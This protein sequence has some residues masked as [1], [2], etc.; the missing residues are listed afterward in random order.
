[1]QQKCNCNSKTVSNLLKDDD[2]S[3]LANQM[4]KLLPLPPLL[5][6]KVEI[7][8]RMVGQ[9]SFRVVS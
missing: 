8:L 7:Y 4:I 1:M 2:A 6:P 5:T 3:Q 9:Y